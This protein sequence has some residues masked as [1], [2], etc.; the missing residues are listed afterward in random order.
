MA[1]SQKDIDIAKARKEHAKVEKKNA[2]LKKE[3]NKNASLYRSGWFGVLIGVLS[4]VFFGLMFVPA[5]ELQVTNQTITPE[6]LNLFQ[7]YFGFTCTLT[8]GEQT[9]T[10]NFAAEFWFGGFVL[11]LIVV[12]AI[13]YCFMNNSL[14]FGFLGIG[15]D[16]GAGVLMVLLMS[17]FTLINTPS[18][19]S[20]F[21]SVTSKFTYGYYIALAYVFLLAVI[22]ILMIV[23]MILKSRSKAYDVYLH[24]KKLVNY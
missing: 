18:N 12:G 6:K 7:L 23:V 19:V 3:A 13:L 2:Q 24:G 16:V 11:V 1:K 10:E 17:R 8:R 22:G 20:Q 4:L 14:L 9:F 5:C 15:A 21:N